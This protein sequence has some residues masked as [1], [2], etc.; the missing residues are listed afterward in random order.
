MS[1]EITPLLISDNKSAHEVIF[2]PF[3][4]PYII[5]LDGSPISS[6]FATK[7]CT[8]IGSQRLITRL[9]TPLLR[10]NRDLVAMAK[11]CVKCVLKLLSRICFR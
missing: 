9:D 2:L 10:R 3:I 7:G 11:A 1:K 6:F 4:E 8:R 5:D